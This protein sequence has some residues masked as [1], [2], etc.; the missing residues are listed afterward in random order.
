M[1]RERIEALPDE[2]WRSRWPDFQEPRLS[3]SLRVVDVLREIAAGR[4]CAPGQVAIAWTL[5]DAAVAGAT[6]GFRA[7]HQVDE[8]AAAGG[9]R[10]DPDEL[11]RLDAVRPVEPLFAMSMDGEVRVDG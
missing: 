1:T 11:A 5:R 2:D 3:E 6:V 7:P 10:L 9:L 4:G 8:L